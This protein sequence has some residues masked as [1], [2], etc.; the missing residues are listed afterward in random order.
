LLSRSLSLGIDIGGTNTKVVVV[1]RQ[2]TVVAQGAAATDRSGPKAAI[3]SAART[4]ITLLDDHAISPAQLNGLGL[5]IPGHITEDGR[6]ATIVP[7]IPGRWAELDIV[8]EVEQLLGRSPCVINDARAFGLAEA[9]W[10]A[11]AGATFMLGVVLG[12]GVGGVITDRGKIVGGGLGNAGEVGHMV[13]DPDGPPCGC[14]ALGCLEA[15][16]RSDVV[17][18]AA[19]TTTVGEARLRADAGDARAINALAQAGAHLGRGLA[20]AATLLSPDRIVVGGGVSGAGSWLLD[21]LVDHLRRNAPLVPTAA[22]SLVLAQLGT[23]AGAIGA[24]L[25]ARPEL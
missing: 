19:G 3:F 1:G 9:R 8:G 17:A 10:G 22:D 11:G 6:R 25:W 12:T 7:N 24:A 14:G 5:T 2:G 16:V 23:N 15:F 20:M 13:I 4:A 18:L 21:P